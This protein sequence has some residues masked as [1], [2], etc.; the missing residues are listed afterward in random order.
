M[1]S[2]STLTAMTMVLSFVMECSWLTMSAKGIKHVCTPEWWNMDRTAV[3]LGCV[4][5]RQL[6]L[7]D[8]T[9][10]YLQQRGNIM[11]AEKIETEKYWSGQSGVEIR[12]SSTTFTNIHTHIYMHTQKHT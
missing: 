2:V 6:K 8:D 3:P 5:K 12:P 1:T 10:K 7:R 11:D 4:G 9:W